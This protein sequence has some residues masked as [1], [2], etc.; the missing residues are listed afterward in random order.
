MAAKKA[1]S[2]VLRKPIDAVISRTD[3]TW[4]NFAPEDV[5]VE[6]SDSDPA[7]AKAVA[8]YPDHF[9]AV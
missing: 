7:V 4:A 1:K 2:Y 5:G 9:K 3:E 8:M 6:F